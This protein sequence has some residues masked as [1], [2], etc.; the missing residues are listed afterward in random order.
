MDLTANIER[1]R[2]GEGQEVFLG[3]RKVFD[4]WWWWWW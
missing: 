2:D 4:E 1:S 3:L